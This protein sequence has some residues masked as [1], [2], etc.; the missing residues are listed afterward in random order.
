MAISFLIQSEKNPAPIYVRLREGRLIDA[1]TKTG[2][3]ID[4]Q[5]F[6]KNKVKLIRMISG[7]DAE[8]KKNI[9]IQNDELNKLQTKLDEIR[10][11]ISTALNNREDYETINL[12]WLSNIIDPKRDF[13]IPNLLT[14]FFEFY[15]QARKGEIAGS[16]YKKLNTTKNRFSNFQKD[17]KVL[18]IQEINKS[19][20]QSFKTWC[21]GKY[22]Y[23]T[24]LGSIKNLLTILNYAKENGLPVHPE[25]EYITKG[26]KYKKHERIYLS[27][28]EIEQINSTKILNKDLDAAKDWLVISCYTAQRVSD[29]LNFK[30]ED[31]TIHLKDGIEIPCL[32][33]T[34][35]KTGKPV[36]LP[37]APP[38][39][40]ILNK[41]NGN[42]PPTFST[43]PN[44]NATLYN[45]LIKDVCRLAGLKQ[46][47]EVMRKTGRNKVYEKKTVAKYKAVT[48]HIGRRSFAT[49]YY[50]KIATPLLLDATGHSSERQFQ[51]YVG[52][53]PH[54]N[55]NILYDGMVKIYKETKKKIKKTA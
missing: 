29:F 1:K 43:D 13:E 18:H 27:L 7:A 48:S 3:V 22:D 30:K 42:F 11:S 2:L 45:R 21:T 16:T 9:Q 25:Y 52:K 49:N 23:N 14:D 32:T 6:Q 55:I 50:G 31:V 35:K 53:P 5:H 33:I 46:K 40:K 8:T 34:Q 4:P 37:L 15:L 28:E 36:G 44:S 47:V 24:M 19:V 38:V 12:N 20:V 39:M 54:H 10:T 41:R 26:M 17:Y 51:A